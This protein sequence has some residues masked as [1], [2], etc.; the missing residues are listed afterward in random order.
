MLFRSIAVVRDSVAGS[1]PRGPAENR[2]RVVRLPGARV[3]P[4]VDG[5]L[6]VTVDLLEQLQSEAELAAVL[7]HA[8]AHHD[9]GHIERALAAHPESAAAARDG[10]NGGSDVAALAAAAVGDVDSYSVED[11]VAADAA[12]IAALRVAAWEPKAL[13]IGRAHV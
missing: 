5:T 11:E 4:L 8:Q 10:L 9:L 12:A 6:V 7:A 1:R 13:Q 2:L 3:F